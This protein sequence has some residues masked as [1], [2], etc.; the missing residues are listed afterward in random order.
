MI[1][2]RL[3]PKSSSQCGA[4][5]GA[6]LERQECE[7]SLSATRKVAAKLT[8]HGERE[9]AEDGNLDLSVSVTLSIHHHK[10]L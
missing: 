7:Q 3:R 5:Y 4:A 10:R 8:A 6:I 9:A 1:F 2:G